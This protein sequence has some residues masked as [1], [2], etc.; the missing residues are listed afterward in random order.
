MLLSTVFLWTLRNGMGLANIPGPIQQLIIG[1]L[2]VAGVLLS[3]FLGGRIDI[4]GPRKLAKT[5]PSA[6]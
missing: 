1:A 3:N 5:E 4:A 2:L 6:P